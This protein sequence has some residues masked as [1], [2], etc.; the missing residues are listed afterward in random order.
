MK[1]KWNL[2]LQYKIILLVCG[3]S[4]LCLLVTNFFIQKNVEQTT[5]DH[6]EEKAKTVSKTAAINPIFIDGL[7]GK[8]SGDTIQTYAEQVRKSAG[9]PFLV[10]LDMNGIRLSHPL[11]NKIGKKYAGGD[12]GQVFQGREHISIATGTLGKSLRYFTPVYNHNGKQ[13]GAILV[14]VLLDDVERKVWKST[15]VILF[16]MLLG[17]F[18]GLVC[19]VVFS[20]KVKNI[21]FGME[22][23]EIANLLEQRSAVLEYAREG[24]IAVD[25]Y[26]E[27]TL[28]NQ[29]AGRLIKSVG[30]DCDPIG[31]KIEEIFPQF[32][33]NSLMATGKKLLDKEY[34][35]RGLVIMANIVPTYV[36]NE[37]TG[38]VATFR[39]KTEIRQLAEQLTGARLYADALR[40]QTHEFMNKLHVILGLAQMKIYDQLTDYVKQ[41]SSSFQTEEGFLTARI[42]DPVI[43]G[44]II[45]KSSFAREQGAVLTITENSYFPRQKSN[46]FVQ[47][48][49]TV[50]GNLIDNSIEALKG[51]QEKKVEVEFLTSQN[52][53]LI[54]KVS[55]T[56]MG[57]SQEVEEQ[58]FERGFST[59]G[60]NRGIGMYLVLEAVKKLNG[61]ISILSEPGKG[62]ILQVAIPVAGEEKYHD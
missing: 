29:E 40:S 17:V 30:F 8:V 7:S 57:M 43:A 3:V 22:P 15:K 36:N 48:I 49:V 20:R 45:G 62:A 25:Q 52:D 13:I 56:G 14:G 38:A 18:V 39:D 21:L 55:D 54:I 59:K 51:C 26:G 33:L 35:F 58:I 12:A 60:N 5:I 9:V 27:I 16:S 32:Q 42:K 41:I 47:D 31:M 23:V 4:I 53:E 28:I 50:L 37:I 44:F 10:V 19:A 61:K 34:S 1:N 2:S 46:E 11:P 24:V 6:I